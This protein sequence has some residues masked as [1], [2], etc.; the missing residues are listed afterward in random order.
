MLRVNS[1]IVGATNEQNLPMLTVTDG[2]ALLDH[3]MLP[4]TASKD[5]PTTST[6]WA[7]SASGGSHST[8]TVHRKPNTRQGGAGDVSTCD[9]MEMD[10]SIE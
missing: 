8:S 5:H 4:S 7:E 10:D 1:Y 6:A 2:S 3:S 9:D